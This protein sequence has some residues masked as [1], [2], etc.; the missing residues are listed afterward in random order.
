MRRDAD[1]D[2]ELLAAYVDGVSE[3]SAEERRRIERHLEADPAARTDEAEARALIGALRELPPVASEPDWTTLERSIRDAVGPDAPRVWWRGWKWI[4]PGVALATTAVIVLA[5]QRTDPVETRAP[6]AHEL[7]P[8]SETAPPADDV[9][10][11]TVAL[12][13]D[14]AE[15]DVDLDAEQLLDDPMLG[16]DDLSDDVVGEGLLSPSDLATT[17]DE[18]DEASLQRAEG[19]LDRA[20]L[21]RRKK[22]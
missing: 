4:V 15:I 13:L 6:V 1:R 14:G 3:L 2:S 9:V 21:H 8:S 7:V 16:L 11:E 10:P 17:I 18:L 12:W 5:L 20:Q 19:M 22:S